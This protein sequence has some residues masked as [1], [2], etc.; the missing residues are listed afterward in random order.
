MYQLMYTSEPTVEFSS[1][2]IRELL[3]IARARNK[4]SLITGML[5]FCDRQFL[6]VLE[7]MLPM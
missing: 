7:A 1:Q 4:I 5:V 6:Q 3:A 2:G